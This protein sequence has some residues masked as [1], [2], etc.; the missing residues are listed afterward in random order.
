MLTKGSILL[1]HRAVF[2]KRCGS[3]WRP[4]NEQIIQSCSSLAIVLLSLANQTQR[5][6]LFLEIAMWLPTPVVVDSFCFE[7][8]VTSRVRVTYVWSQSPRFQ[9]GGGCGSA[10]DGILHKPHPAPLRDKSL[11]C[12]VSQTTYATPK[13]C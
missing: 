7:L 11:T 3:P 4:R 5:L 1:E 10:V 6:C 9:V 13:D 2:H 12:S 8:G